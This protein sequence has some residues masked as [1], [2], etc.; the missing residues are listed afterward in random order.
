MGTSPDGGLT[1]TLAQSLG[2]ERALRFLLEMP[3][4]PAKEALEAGLVGEVVAAERFEERFH[5]Y[6]AQLA[7]LPPI[8]VRQSKRMLHRATTPPD[9]SVHATLELANARRGLASEDGKEAMNAF[10]ERRPAKYRG[11]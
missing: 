10:M 8:A 7:A 3:M 5:E 2:Y 9:V 1:W 11:R 6:L 4:M